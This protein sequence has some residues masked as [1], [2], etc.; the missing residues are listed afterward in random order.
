MHPEAPEDRR[1]V[2]STE[3]APARAARAGAVLTERRALKLAAAFSGQHPSGHLQRIYD[4]CASL[5]IEMPT[6]RLTVPQRAVHFCSAL[7]AASDEELLRQ[8]ST[9]PQH[10][11]PTFCDGAF[12]AMNSAF[13]TCT[14]ITRQ[15]VLW[16]SHRL[17]HHRTS[18]GCARASACIADH[19]LC[20]CSLYV[21]LHILL[22]S[23]LRMCRSARCVPLAVAPL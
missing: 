14:S 16:C 20:S 4:S 12:G 3:F 2:H 13:S 21:A 1:F 15:H 9:S 18:I 8:W 17:C 22:H 23:C 10:E 19:H 7:A 5:C 6:Q 11:G